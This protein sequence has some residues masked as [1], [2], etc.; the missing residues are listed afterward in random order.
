M[1]A[2]IPLAKSFPPLSMHCKT[3]SPANIEEV[4]VDSITM[5]L[6]SQYNFWQDTTVQQELHEL[7]FRG[8]QEEGDD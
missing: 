8:T 2:E 7:L 4:I 5:G 1:S 6:G 3:P